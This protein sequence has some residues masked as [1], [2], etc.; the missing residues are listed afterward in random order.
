M[1]APAH[2]DGCRELCG[3]LSGADSSLRL[4]QMFCHSE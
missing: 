4:S 3:G 1:E 2:I